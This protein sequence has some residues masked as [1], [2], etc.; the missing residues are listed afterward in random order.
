MQRETMKPRS[1]IKRDLFA[2]EH[3]SRKIDV[4]GDPQTWIHYPLG[5]SMT[6]VSTRRPRALAWSDRKVEICVDGGPNL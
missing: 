3:H 5:L 6:K 4:L 2:A 1:A